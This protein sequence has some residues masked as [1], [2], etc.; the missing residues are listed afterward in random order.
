M[1]PLAGLA[2]YSF[3]KIIYLICDCAG[4]WL[5]AARAFSSCGKREE[6]SSCGEWAS[7]FGGFS[8]Y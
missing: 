3:F 1:N 5:S 7:H 8:G 4:F 2:L 6:L